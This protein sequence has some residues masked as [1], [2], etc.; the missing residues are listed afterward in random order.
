MQSLSIIKCR[1]VLF[2]LAVFAASVSG[3]CADPASAISGDIPRPVLDVIAAVEAK[4]VFAPAT[5]G[6]HVADLATGE[7]LIDQ[8]GGKALVPASVMKVYSL[9]T[10]LDAYGADYRFRTPVYRLGEVRD[11]VLAGDLVL[12]ASGDFSFGLREQADGTLAFNS[13][14]EVDHNSTY[15][16]FP[17]GAPVRNSDPLAALDAL[18]AEVR[19]AGISEVAGDVLIDDRLF[20]THRG[21]SAGVI[22]PIWV[23]ENVIDITLTPGKPGE[24]PGI[25]WRPKSA[26]VTVENHVT[27]VA[28]QARGLTVTETAA[29]VIRVD[30]EIAADS[31]PV[32][33]IFQVSDPSA[34]ARTAFIEAL[35]RAGVKVAAPPV[36]PAGTL[37]DAGV[38]RDADRVAEYVSPPLSE[39]VKVILKVSYNRG[40][41]LMVCLAA[42]KAGSRDCN[43]GLAEVLKTLARNGISPTSTYPFDGAGTNGNNRTTASDLATFLG[44]IADTP[45]GAAIHDGMAVLGVDGSQAQNGAG[46]PSAGH[47]RI[48]DGDVVSGSAA[49]QMIVIAM[50]QTGFIDARSGRQLVYGI[51]VNNA[52]FPSMADYIAARADVAAI[53][54]AIQQGY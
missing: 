9:A 32:L 8:A 47:V 26:A 1:P 12:V 44:A 18:A 19:A 54:A 29:G 43:V 23:N 35:V 30:G 22:A 48:K 28:G 38:Y 13:L 24:T 42:V 4:P 51:I 45:T 41:D 46:S 11:G 15:T 37:P 14:P 31:P 3:T 34:F 40:A 7:V 17:G 10:A 21:F 53:V 52:P 16:G 2:A 25:D 50:S 6:I 5:W 27:T 49:G 39:F 20:E 36:G 33:T